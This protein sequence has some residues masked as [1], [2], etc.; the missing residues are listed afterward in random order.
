MFQTQILQVKGLFRD[1]RVWRVLLLAATI[2]VGIAYVWQ[3]N[4]A[5]TAGYAMRELDGA[6]EDLTLEQERLDLQVARLQS[7]DSVSTR[8]QMLGLQQVKR[9]EYLTPGTGAVAIN[10]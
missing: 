3:V 10:R 7:I 6:I 8:V 9:I 2:A 1:M 4:Q 5:A